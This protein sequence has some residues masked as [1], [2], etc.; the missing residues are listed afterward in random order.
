[1]DKLHF[2]RLIKGVREMKRHI[3]AN[4]STAVQT[5]AKRRKLEIAGWKIGDTKEFLQL[6]NTQAALVERKISETGTAKPKPK[7]SRL[8]K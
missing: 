3:T 4:T 5:E 6:T 1:M 7:P 8:R 2:D